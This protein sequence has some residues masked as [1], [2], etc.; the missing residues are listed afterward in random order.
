MAIEF[1]GGVVL[2]RG[3]AEAAADIRHESP[4][5]RSLRNEPGAQPKHPDIPPRNVGPSQGTKQALPCRPMQLEFPPPRALSKHV[6][7][8]RRHLGTSQLRKEDRESLP[9]EEGVLL[10]GRPRRRRAEM[11][12]LRHGQDAP[13]AD[14]AHGPENALQCVRGPVQVWAVGAGVSACGEPNV[15]ADK[16]LQLT[17]EGAGA[18]APEGDGADPASAAVHSPSG[19]GVRRIQ[20]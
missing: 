18:S 17:S 8:R 1:R 16:A 20:R 2:Q 14:W 15:Y 4:D 7:R 9:E 13:V 11:P 3:P 6:R 5:R 19:Y 10:P 12:A